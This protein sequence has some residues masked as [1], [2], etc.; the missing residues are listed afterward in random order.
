MYLF[1][2]N[3]KINK[4]YKYILMMSLLLLNACSTDDGSLT[5]PSS[6][7]GPDGITEEQEFDAYLK[8]KRLTI[9][10]PQR[11][12]SS[13]KI[14]LEDKALAKAVTQNTDFDTSLIDAEVEDLRRSLLVNQYV[15][16]ELKERITDV[17]LKEYFEKNRQQFV[18]GEFNLI[19]FIFPARNIDSVKYIEKAKAESIRVHR[20]L[21]KGMDV[22]VMISEIDKNKLSAVDIYPGLYKKHEW[23]SE[24]YIK[25]TH[26]P[27]INKINNNGVTSISQDESGF[28]FFYLLEPK[29]TIEPVFEDVAESIRR[30][31]YR[32]EKINIKNE[33]LKKI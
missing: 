27:L 7:I 29:R 6:Y 14:Y 10:N 15:V 5:S 1:G 19:Q 23:I 21:S 3:M 18:G 32:S 26:I 8:Y 17:A 25:N 22:N 11:Y 20:K 12:Q 2:L 24:K 9:N 30:T 33:L 4:V 28:V 31:L 16:R 13:F